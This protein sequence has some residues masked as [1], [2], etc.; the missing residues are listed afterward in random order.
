MTYLQAFFLI[1]SAVL[2][3][4]RTA[5]AQFLALKEIGGGISTAWI[6][7][8]NPA[9]DFMLP[10]NLLARTDS[11]IIL[12]GGSLDGQ[13]FGLGARARFGLG[14][15]S[16]AFTLSLGVDYI[17]YRGNWRLPLSAG[18]ILMEHNV[19]MPTA[20]LGL[21]YRVLKVSKLTGLYVA[22][23]ARAAFIHS[24]FFN[25]EFKAADGELH[26]QRSTTQ[27]KVSATRL[28]AAL[29]LGFSGEFQN[30]LIID[31]SVGYGAVNLVG[32]DDVR[33]QLLTTTNDYETKEDVVGNILFSIM[34]MYRI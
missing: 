11:L 12:P 14:S 8:A 13:Q 24:T 32:R 3:W 34:V 26:E 1:A 18:S 4:G 9:R 20:I 7:G 10:E 17:F 27:G 33:G 21:E 5:S 6:N 30:G 2:L 29:R 23:E 16:S 28:G 22:A 31:T 25:W 19:D 15:D